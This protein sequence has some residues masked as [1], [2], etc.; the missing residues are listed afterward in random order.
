MSALVS[1]TGSFGVPFRGLETAN[2]T[3]HAGD[4]CDARSRPVEVYSGCCG[5]G[6]E[7]HQGCGAISA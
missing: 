6:F 4:I 2:A 5:W 3:K 7:A 1:Q